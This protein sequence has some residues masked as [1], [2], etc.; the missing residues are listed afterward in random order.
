[1]ADDPFQNW[2]EPTP[3]SSSASYASG[4]S[5]TPPQKKRR[6]EEDVD[7]TYNP[8]HDE[9]HSA[10]IPVVP[11]ALDF[12]SGEE[13]RH[14]E[15]PAPSTTAQNPSRSGGGGNTGGTRGS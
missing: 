2:R 11:R 13:N 9:A 6:T 8:A 3:S 5:M 12:G 7:P 15:G 10:Q 14:E 4:A 1:M